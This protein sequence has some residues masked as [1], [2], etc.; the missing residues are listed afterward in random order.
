MTPVEFSKILW[1]KQITQ[2]RPGDRTFCKF[3]RR[4]EL[5]IEWIVPFTWAWVKRNE[6]KKI[7]TDVYFAWELKKKKKRN[8]KMIVMPILV[9]VL[10][11]V[12]KFLEKDCQKWR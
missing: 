2:T 4:K 8:L 12:C 10:G 3:S 11:T 6:S 7:N 9:R 1:Y 5:V